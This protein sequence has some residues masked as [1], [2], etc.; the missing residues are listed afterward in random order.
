MDSFNDYVQKAL[1]GN[2]VEEGLF[3]RL[4][5]NFQGLKSKVGAAAS[6]IGT[7]GKAVIGGTGT[8]GLKL[9][10][11]NQTGLDSKIQ[12]IAKS[13]ATEM[14]NDFYKMGFFPEGRKPSNQN[15]ADLVSNITQTIQNISKSSGVNPEATPEA[16]TPPETTAEVPPETETA[17]ETTTE[18]P[19]E[20][21]PE[22][23]TT[24]E[25]PPKPKVPKARS[26]KPGTLP[27]EGRSKRRRGKLPAAGTSAERPSNFF[28]NFIKKYNII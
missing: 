17:P 14:L 9:Q 18:A 4:N 24:T 23:E 16:E 27:P 28:D 5:A 20:T 13:H 7:V 6:N 22:T 8:D 19:P 11:I 25:E 12:A 10:N 2:T 26:R 1:D 3:S 21:A 15:I